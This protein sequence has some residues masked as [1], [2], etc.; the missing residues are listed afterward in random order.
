MLIGWSPCGCSL[1]LLHW[2]AR[3]YHHRTHTLNAQHTHT[4]IYDRRTMFLSTLLRLA[5]MPHNA[6]QVFPAHTQIAY[7]MG[8]FA[9]NFRIYCKIAKS[10]HRIYLW[11]ICIYKTYHFTWHCVWLIWDM[12]D[13]FAL[14]LNLLW[15]SFVPF[16]SHDSIILILQRTRNEAS[17]ICD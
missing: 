12:V 6:L 1:L 9:N 2:L 15:N 16:R 11:I 13:S 8:T 5:C 17:E 7:W 10:T 3:C 4:T 14:N